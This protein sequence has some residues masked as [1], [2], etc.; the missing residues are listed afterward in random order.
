MFLKRKKQKK[1]LE[2]EIKLEKLHLLNK[3]KIEKKNDNLIKLVA[4]QDLLIVAYKKISGIVGTN[5]KSIA[6]GFNWKLV[7]NI[8]K[9]ILNETY[10]WK[11]I[12]QVIIGKPEK[13]KVFWVSYFL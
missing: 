5:E 10:A 6:N 13:K 11:N 3:K 7:N 12:K 4:Y 8:S 2:I 9:S 1:K